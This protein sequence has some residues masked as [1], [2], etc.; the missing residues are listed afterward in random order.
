MCSHRSCSSD[1]RVKPGLCVLL[2]VVLRQRRARQGP[3]TQPEELGKYLGLRTNDT[4]SHAVPE[5]GC[6]NPAQYFCHFVHLVTAVTAV[7]TSPIRNNA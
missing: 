4:V 6:G 3:G 2:T 5:Q 7:Q 1:F